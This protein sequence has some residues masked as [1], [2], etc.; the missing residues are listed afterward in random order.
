MYSGRGQKGF[1]VK[2]ET[3]KG[4]YFIGVLLS[5]MGRDFVKNLVI[6]Y[7]DA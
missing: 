4:E 2:L 6:V 5:K 3:E 7:G 1:L